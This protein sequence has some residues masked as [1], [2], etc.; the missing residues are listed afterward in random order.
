MGSSQ[1]PDGLGQLAVAGDQPMIVAVGADQVSQHL[2]VA[3]IRL[4]P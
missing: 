3:W 1:H 2:G 4:R